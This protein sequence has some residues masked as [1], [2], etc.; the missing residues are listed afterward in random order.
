MSNDLL[1][2]RDNSVSEEDGGGLVTTGRAWAMFLT[3]NDLQDLLN[4]IDHEYDLF[5]ADVAAS[6]TPP[7]PAEFKIQFARQLGAWKTFRKQ[8]E[9]SWIPPSSSAPFDEADRYES[10]LVDFREQFAGYGGKL[11]SPAVERPKGPEAD[12]ED[13]YLSLAKGAL[14]VG[15]LAAVAYALSQARGI[16]SGFSPMARTR[17]VVAEPK[18][19][20]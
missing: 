8:H 5:A 18:R 10:R 20:K 3:D 2:G 4:R 14:F 17:I 13:D 9:P 12:R 16:A 7:V 19:R 15:G 1:Y 11:T 6:P